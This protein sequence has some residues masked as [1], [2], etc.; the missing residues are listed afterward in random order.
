VIRERGGVVEAFQ[1]AAIREVFGNPFQ[2]LAPRSFPAHVEAL[3]QSC[4]DAF[5]AVSGDYAV[6]ADALEELG[7]E[8]AAQHCR[9]ARHYRGCHVL[10]WLHGWA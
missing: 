1:C 3:A 4:Y 8:W 7:E 9:E 5:P 2:P 10:D 6:L